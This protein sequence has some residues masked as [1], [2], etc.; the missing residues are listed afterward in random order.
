MSSSPILDRNHVARKFELGIRFHLWASELSTPPH[1]EQ[2]VKLFGVSR[3]TAFR[4]IE[5]WRDATATRQ[6]RSCQLD[7]FDRN[8]SAPVPA[9]H[10]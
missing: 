1:W 10:A 2:V 5:S 7:L 9:V 8:K 3:A 4:Y 6:A